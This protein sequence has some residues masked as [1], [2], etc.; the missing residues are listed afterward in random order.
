MKSLLHDSV[1]RSSAASNQASNRNGRRVLLFSAEAPDLIR[2]KEI[3]AQGGY[4]VCETDDRRSTIGLV[5]RSEPDVMVL[6]FDIL[7]TRDLEFFRE[8]SAIR[9]FVVSPAVVIVGLHSYAIANELRKLGISQYLRKPVA[10]GRLLRTIHGCL[11]AVVAF[12]ANGEVL[13]ALQ[14]AP[15]S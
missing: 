13:E 2:L 3:L 1:Y 6:S 5:S 12:R 9:S 10:R 4:E 7:S 8:L 11:D 14:A 15:A